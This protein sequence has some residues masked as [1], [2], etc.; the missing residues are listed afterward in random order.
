MSSHQS[1]VMISDEWLTPP[2]IMAKLGAFDLDPCSPLNRP[3][4]T[5]RRHF[6]VAD[7]GLGKEWFGRV[8]M[9]PPFGREATRWMKKMADHGNGIALIPARTET[10]MFYESVW[11]RADAVLFIK[12]RP[13]FHRVDGTRASF[14]S[15][16]PICLV[17]YGQ[18]NHAELLKS[19]LGVVV[20][21]P[22]N[23]A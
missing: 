10:A 16:A 6:T 15:G 1:P 19:G 11:S 14:N 5:A 22:R 4:D 21:V 13:H 9:N 8:W 20:A 3:W 17:A 23:A 12:G 18:R 7:D 2:E